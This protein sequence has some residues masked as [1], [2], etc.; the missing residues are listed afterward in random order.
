MPSGIKRSGLPEP[1]AYVLV[2]IDRD[3]QKYRGNTLRISRDGRFIFGST[4]GSSKDVRGFVTAFELD[5]KGYLKS[6]DAVAYY[7]TPTSGGI[8]G[9]IEPAFWKGSEGIAA[10]DYVLLVDEEEGS[11]RVLGWSGFLMRFSEIAHTSL[12]DCVTASH[13]IWLS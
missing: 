1:S 2:G 9:A 5:Q 4:R 3:S 8:A 7:E 12:P 10:Q 11:V 13:A 6:T